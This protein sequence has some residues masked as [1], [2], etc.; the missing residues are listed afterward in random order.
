[1]QGLSP[2]SPGS[3]ASTDAQIVVER[4]ASPGSVPSAAPAPCAAPNALQRRQGGCDLRGSRGG[5]DGDEAQLVDPPA[6][7]APSSAPRRRSAR[8]TR[9]SCGKPSA[10]SRSGGARCA[11]SSRLLMSTACQRRGRSRFWASRRSTVRYGAQRAA[12]RRSTPGG[13][14]KRRTRPGEAR[15]RAWALMSPAALREHHAAS[16]ARSAPIST[17]LDV[18]R[19][20]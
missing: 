2:H 4:L 7:Q 13:Y 1:M 16:Q 11:W 12:A 14:A 6:R 9:P 19:V 3:V 5:G 10:S 8:T 20:G 17:F 18:Q 15:A